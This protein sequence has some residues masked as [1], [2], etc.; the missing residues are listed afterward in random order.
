MN[1]KTTKAV[2]DFES[3]LKN[4]NDALDLMHLISQSIDNETWTHT[5]LYNDY[6]ATT[7]KG[8]IKLQGSCFTAISEYACEIKDE[9]EA[10]KTK[11]KKVMPGL[12]QK[13]KS[14][15]NYAKKFYNRYVAI[16]YNRHQGR[17]SNNDHTRKVSQGWIVGMS[18]R[19]FEVLFF[20]ASSYHG[21]A[22]YEAMKNLDFHRHLISWGNDMWTTS[23]E[24]RA[25]DFG[26]LPIDKNLL[27]KRNKELRRRHR[28]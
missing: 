22:Y 26:D 5:S 17:F 14:G 1:L 11:L 9:W 8:F 24:L 15:K 16:L 4:L 23:V 10:L 3:E 7:K 28:R 2:K 12:F 20:N 25:E 13:G 19:D 6:H 21:S 27:K 18:I